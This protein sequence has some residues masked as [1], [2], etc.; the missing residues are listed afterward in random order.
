[1]RPI[2][3]EGDIEKRAGFVQDGMGD[4]PRH[5]QRLALDAGPQRERRSFLFPSLAAL[6]RDAAP[7]QSSAVYELN[8]F[9]N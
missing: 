9:L 2:Q 1:M 8:L 5:Q 3:A 4:E 7:K 6:C